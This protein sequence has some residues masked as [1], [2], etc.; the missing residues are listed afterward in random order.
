[1][2]VTVCLSA[3]LF[4][5]I[6]NPVSKL[7]EMA[8]ARS[9]SNDSAIFYVLPVLWMT[10]CVHNRRSEGNASIGRILKV[11]RQGAEPGRSLMSTIALLWP[12][13]VADADIIF[14][15]CGFFLSSIF[16]YSSPNLSGRSLDVYPTSTHTVALVRI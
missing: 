2:S 16:F 11:T 10:S 9:F 5:Y 15:P 12:P 4:S 7:H 14:L 8:V 1:M 6:E 3:C 13:C